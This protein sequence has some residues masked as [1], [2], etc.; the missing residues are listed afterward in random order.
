MDIREN[1]ADLRRRIGE[2]ARAAGRE[3]G[4]I[5]LIAA[6]KTR[7]PQEI[8]EVLAAGVTD[9]GE[10]K[11]Q[12]LLDKYEAVQSADWHMIGHL[13]RNKVK[14]IIDK[15]KLIHSV[16]SLRL[17]EEIDARAAQ[18]GLVKDI[19]VQVNA[20]GEE[21]KFGVAAQ[22]AEALVCEILDNCSHVRIRGFMGVAPAADDPEDVRVY[23]RQV[24]AVFDAFRRSSHERLDMQYLSMGMS[25]DFGAAILEGANMVR[26]GTAIFGPRNYSQPQN[27]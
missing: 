8:N 13:Q 10:N 14:Y 11:V 4:E 26:V 19:L 20:A 23:F 12:E 25:H 17:A 1:I 21:S 27:F 9:I 18:C 2:Y 16:D 6:A 15:V 22:E 5:T 24:K 7:T 3:A